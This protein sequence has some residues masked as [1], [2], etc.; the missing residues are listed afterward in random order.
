MGPETANYVLVMF[1]ILKVFDLT[2]DFTKII[3][4][5]QR[6]KSYKILCTLLLIIN[7]WIQDFFF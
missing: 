3:G 1:W 5:I 6:P 4:K 2:F 7:I